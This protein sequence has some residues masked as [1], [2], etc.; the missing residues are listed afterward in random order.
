M[1][2]RIRVEPGHKPKIAERD[3]GDALGLAGKD[4]AKKELA[5]L[6]IRLED[7]HQR[8]FAESRRSVLLVLQGLDASGKDGVIRAVMRGVNP[9]GCRVVSFRAPSSTELAHDYLWRIHA[10][11][12]VRGE[13]GI[14]NRSHYEDIVAVRMLDLAPKEVW[15]RRPQHINEFERTLSDEGTTVVKVFL[16]VSKDEQRKRFQERIDDPKKRWKFRKADLDVRARFDEYVEAWEN[17]IGETSTVWA[18]W[19]IVPADRNW[20]KAHAVAT[21]LVHTLEKL[22]PQFPDPEPGIEG[23]EIE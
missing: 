7:L 16:N 6:Q 3:P 5:E 17:A 10:V 8:L 23:L 21:L 20:V 13:L 15:N 9:Q 12:P 2:D 14:F 1:I 19:H 22:D 11:L 4:E 18:P